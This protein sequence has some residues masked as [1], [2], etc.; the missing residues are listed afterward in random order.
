[1]HK[2]GYCENCDT[3][4][5]YIIKDKLENDHLNGVDIEYIAKYA[6]C[7]I[8]NTEIYIEKIDDINIATMYNIYR[9]KANIISIDEIETILKKYNIGASRLSILLGWDKYTIPN[10]LNGKVPSKYNSDKLKNILNM[11]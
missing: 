4:V 11:K 2:R 6:Y 10:Y 8:C 7:D 3:I 1:M 9:E 5:T